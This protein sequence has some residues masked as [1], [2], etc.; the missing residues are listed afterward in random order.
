ML[1]SRDIGSLIFMPPL[2]ADEPSVSWTNVALGGAPGG[3]TVTGST[4]L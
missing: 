3:Q 2:S 4:A 1:R